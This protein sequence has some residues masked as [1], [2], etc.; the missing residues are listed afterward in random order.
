MLSMSFFLIDFV[1]CNS[2]IAVAY[3]SV[4]NVRRQ[5]QTM[6]LLVSHNIHNVATCSDQ[7]YA[8]RDAFLVL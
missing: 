5:I 7:V 3:D 8:L 1:K 6:R 2:N 4:G